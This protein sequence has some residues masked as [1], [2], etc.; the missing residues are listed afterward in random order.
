MTVNTPHRHH[1]VR[2]KQEQAGHE[3]AGAGAASDEVII[4]PPPA[5]SAGTTGNVDQSGQLHTKMWSCLRA[6]EMRLTSDHIASWQSWYLMITSKATDHVRSM[7]KGGSPTGLS[8]FPV[9]VFDDDSFTV[10]RPL[11]DTVHCGLQDTVAA[12]RASR[13]C[14]KCYNSERSLRGTFQ[15]ER[16]SHEWAA[17]TKAQRDQLIEENR[18]QGTRPGVRRQ[19]KLTEEASL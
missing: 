14:H 19:V 8:C 1:Q 12:G 16:R 17:M 11:C 2:V 6:L 4:I 3:D 18:E 7:P 13:K 5:E 15:R 10:Q 9:R